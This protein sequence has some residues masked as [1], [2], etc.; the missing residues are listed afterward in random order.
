[1]IYKAFL[2]LIVGFLCI[3]AL[4]AEEGLLRQGHPDRHV[5]VKGDTLWDIA[6]RFLEQP[7]RWPDIWYV[8]PNIENPHLIYPGDV[9]VLTLVD[10]EPR[11]ALKR[12]GHTAKLSPQVRVS[13][14]PTAIPTIPMNAIRPFLSR[15]GVVGPGELES[16]PYVVEIA[17]E[18]VIGGPG[19]RVYVRTIDQDSHQ[20]YVTFRPGDVY[21]DPVTDEV[22]GYEAI[23]LGDALLRS[24]GD[25]ASLDLVSA[26]QEINIGDR[27]VPSRQEEV[28]PNF[29][30]HAPDFQVAGQI[31]SVLNG[32]SQIGQ[33]QVVVL[34]RGEREGLEPGHVLSVFETGK[35]IR[36]LV[37]EDADDEVRLP[38]EHAG[39]LLV[40]RT[41]DRV[42]YGL[43]MQ[44][45]R[46]MHLLDAV[47]SP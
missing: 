18:H 21:R 13:P 12:G 29:I 17:G 11:L 38:D 23:Y 4:W 36:D 45:N 8:N 34:N 31:I 35:T 6:E 15:T 46:A 32:V 9:I 39:T 19:N 2:G 28:Q 25:P 22:L 10:G 3:D 47:R 1:M 33:Y 14:L 41:F 16:A 27:L 30:P 42:S 24:A 20:N 40:F 5:V 43:I 37:G 7:W 26:V 44:A